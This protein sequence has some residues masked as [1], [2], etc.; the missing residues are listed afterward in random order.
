MI[1]YGYG[2]RRYKMNKI[3]GG[4]Q[5]IYGILDSLIPPQGGSGVPNKE[6]I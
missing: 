6:T 3:N 5:P 2:K 1:N 4:Y